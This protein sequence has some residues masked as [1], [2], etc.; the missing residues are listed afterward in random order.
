MSVVVVLNSEYLLV[1][2]FVCVLCKYNIIEYG[3]GAFHSNR[4]KYF[5][6]G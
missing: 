2:L 5:K 3:R 4:Q 6:P 1:V